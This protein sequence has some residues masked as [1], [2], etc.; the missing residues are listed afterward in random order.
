M[1]TLDAYAERYDD[2]QHNNILSRDNIL[3]LSIIIF[4]VAYAECINYVCY[5][6]RPYSKCG[7]NEF[8]YTDYHYAECHCTECCGVILVNKGKLSKTR[9]PRTTILSDRN[10]WNSKTYLE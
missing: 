7:Y 10:L 6:E 8:H 4:T 9:Q 2:I 3:T 1:K 5:V